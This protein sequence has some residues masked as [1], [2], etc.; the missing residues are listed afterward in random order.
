MKN[1]WVLTVPLGVLIAS[2]GCVV[3]DRDVQ[4]V[5]TTPGTVVM[6]NAPPYVWDSAA[7]LGWDPA[8]GDDR[9]SFEATVDDPNGAGDVFG[10]WADVYDDWGGGVSV[11]SVELQPTGDP[12]LWVADV[13]NTWDG[14]YLDPYWGG[15]SVDFVVYDWY[16]A[17]GVMTVPLWT[18]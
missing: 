15:Y 6:T 14:L 10:V 7:W 11:G 1:V 2:T 13:Y 18:Y 16:E 4:V 3:H 8:A 5:T 17:E 9:V 12:T